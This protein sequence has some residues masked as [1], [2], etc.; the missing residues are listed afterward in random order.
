[1]P[2]KRLT[3]TYDGYTL[4]DSDVAEFNWSEN[5]DGISVKGLHRPRQPGATL[6]DLFRGGSKQD[7]PAVSG[8]Q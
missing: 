7:A 8:P 4:F 2:S 3:I 6:A 5:E 1:M